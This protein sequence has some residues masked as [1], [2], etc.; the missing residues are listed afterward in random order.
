MG[1]SAGFVHASLLR[2]RAELYPWLLDE[3]H[4]ATARGMMAA[5]QTDAQSV[6]DVMVRRRRASSADC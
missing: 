5:L 2:R 3:P 6:T 1:T 4:R